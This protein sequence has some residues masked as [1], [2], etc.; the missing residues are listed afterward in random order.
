VNH[1]LDKFCG[2]NKK[3]SPEAL[4]CFSEYSW[5]GNVR[6]L[7]NMVERIVLLT[8]RELILSEDL[9][10][11]I[12]KADANVAPLPEI[13][14]EGVDFESIMEQIEKNYLLKALE[15]SKGIKT[16]AARLL[17]LSFR[18]FRHKLYKYGIK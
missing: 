2:S 17:N 6:E 7:E 11:E 12:I 18:S 15:K 4:R 10:E 8:D 1:F 9:P 5:K 14:E 16:E 13:G 3:F